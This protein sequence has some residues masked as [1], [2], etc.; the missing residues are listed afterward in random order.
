M[1]DGILVACIGNIFLGDDGFGFEVAQALAQAALPPRV[2]VHDY[3]IRG[4][5][6]AYTLLCPWKAV[7]LVDAIARGGEP[8]TLY[9]LEP[10]VPPAT[11][12]ASF[13]PHVMDPARVL[14]TARSLGPVSAAIYI[15]GCEP[16]SLGDETEGRMTLSPR[17]AAAI[18]EAVAMVQNLAEKL[19]PAALPEK[20][21]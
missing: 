8:G 16:E 14:A 5:D 19:T 1:N 2:E 11:V 13:D 15:V 7:I 6:L 18:P 21:A 4:F 10:G 20:A 12:E 9:L 17:V 3:G